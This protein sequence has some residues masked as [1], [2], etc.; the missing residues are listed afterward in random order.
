MAGKSLILREVSID[1]PFRIAQRRVAPEFAACIYGADLPVKALKI[2]KAQG[3]SR[4]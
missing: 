4:K 2:Q 1:P 3:D